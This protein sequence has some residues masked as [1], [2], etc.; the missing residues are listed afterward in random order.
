M[1]ELAGMFENHPRTAL[2]AQHLPDRPA[3]GAHAL[4]PVVVADGVLPVRQHSPVVELAAVDATLRAQ[5]HAVVDLV[6]AGDDGD[7]NGARRLGDL[8]RH[9]AEPAGAAP[10]QHR[11]AAPHLVLG[12]A[13]QHSPGGGGDQHVGSRLLPG[14]VLRLGHALVRLHPGE[15]SETA[16]V[17]LVAPNAERGRV[18][19]IVAGDHPGILRIP[20]GAVDHDL[21]A[22]F[23]VLD[24][25]ADL[26]DDAR[27]IRA[28]DVEVFLLARL[29]PG[30]DDID[31]D[32][33]GGPDVVVIDA[34]RHDVDQHL[35]VL[36]R[37]DVDDLLLE[38]RRR[39][40][41]PTLAD[42]PRVHLRRHLA[43]RRL[44]PDRVQ[45]FRHG[46]HHRRPST[47][48]GRFLV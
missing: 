47:S 1:V 33:E 37:G 42:Q 39:L 5:L 23:H 28:A 21:I 13:V 9:R 10:N 48:F 3:E 29:L 40:T 44:F 2:L 38:R 27:G 30:L 32:A 34:R 24:V 7:R 18:H 46:G 14:H 36:D 35:V 11:V 41:E 17:G 6:F 26:V 4:Q 15:L 25:L 16:V 43:E 8:D 31:R 12:P 20:G 22:D 19:R 45:L